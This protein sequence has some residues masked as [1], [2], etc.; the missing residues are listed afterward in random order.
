MLLILAWLFWD[1]NI[2]QV[3]EKPIVQ[4]QKTEVMDC[5]RSF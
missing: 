3:A 2:K 4:A 5:Y 1:S